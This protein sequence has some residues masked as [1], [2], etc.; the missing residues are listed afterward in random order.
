MVRI[1]LIDYGSGNLRSVENALRRAGVEVLWCADG[2]A[3]LA[4][5]DAVVLPGVGSFGDCAA[6]LD[7]R[8]LRSPLLG[9]LQAGRPYL[10][11]CLGY[12]ILFES[13]EESPGVA[14]LGFLAGRVVRF[15]RRPGLKVPH[16]G[17]NTLRRGPA[18]GPLLEGLDAEPAVFFVHSYFPRPENPGLVAAWTD[19]DGAF[20]SAVRSGEVCGVQFHPEKSQ[21]VGLR[22]L[23]NFL[24][25][26]HQAPVS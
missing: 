8:G 5:C 10:G 11:I 21:T 24:S 20:A 19:Y 22:I 18:C 7:Q 17:W 16:M 2:D 25:S 12:Q 3:D 23:Q 15:P 4:S 1:A 13:S 9:W 26:V 14:G 6:N